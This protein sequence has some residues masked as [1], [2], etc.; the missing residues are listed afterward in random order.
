MC[1]FQAVAS[2]TWT[3][4]T[5]FEE[6]LGYHLPWVVASGGLAA[7]S[8]GRISTWT[9]QPRPLN[10]SASKQAKSVVSDAAAEYKWYSPS[11]FL[12]SVF[13]CHIY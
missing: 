2:T 6:G 8:S 7:I 1:H 11:L 3:R 5:R 10:E 9:P 12:F 13:V 4:L